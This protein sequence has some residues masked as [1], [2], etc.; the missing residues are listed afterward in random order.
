[1]DFTLCCCHKCKISIMRCL[2]YK[3]NGNYYCLECCYEEIKCKFCLI[4]LLAPMEEECD[5]CIIIYSINN[6]ILTDRLYT[7]KHHCIIPIK[8]KYMNVNIL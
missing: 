4:K 7:I 6:L 3:I 1:M 2:L 8:N 5:R